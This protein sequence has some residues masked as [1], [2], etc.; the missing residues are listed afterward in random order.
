MFRAVCFVLG[1][2]SPGQ[3]LHQDCF[4]HTWIC[5]KWCLEHL[6]HLENS[7][8]RG[9]WSAQHKL[10]VQWAGDHAASQPKLQDLYHASMLLFLPPDKGRVVIFCRSCHQNCR[11]PEGI[12]SDQYLKGTRK[13]LL[14]Y[15]L[16]L[17]HLQPNEEPGSLV[18]ILYTEI[19]G[20]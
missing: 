1:R 19:R 3:S 16:V 15:L 2:T 11:A 13:L 5:S 10:L 17:S 12:G 8:L 4:C 9:G 6:M 14:L 7:I 18:C 20:C